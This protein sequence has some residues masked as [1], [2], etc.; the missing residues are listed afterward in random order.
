MKSPE[1]IIN[2]PI[3]GSPNL[4]T[5]SYWKVILN[6]LKYKLD[7]P[8]NSQF[9]KTLIYL[10]IFSLLIKYLISISFRTALKSHSVK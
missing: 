9:L 5:G 1:I 3:D 8:I 2:I 10:N 4:N 7:S 6:E